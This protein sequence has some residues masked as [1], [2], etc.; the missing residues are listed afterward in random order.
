M[1][2][3]SWYLTPNKKKWYQNYCKNIHKNDKEMNKQILLEMLSYGTKTQDIELI[4][5]ASLHGR[6]LIKYFFDRDRIKDIVNSGNTNFAI[7]I[8]EALYNNYN[9]RSYNYDNYSLLGII[10]NQNDDISHEIIRCLIK[11]TKVGNSEPI[12]HDI[13]RYNVSHFTAIKCMQS[14][15]YDKYYDLFVFYNSI[16]TCEYNKLTAIDKKTTLDILL[17]LEDQN[18]DNSAFTNLPG[19]FTNL[20]GY[21][22]DLPGYFTNPSF[23]KILKFLISKNAKVSCTTINIKTINI[24]YECGYDFKISLENNAKSIVEIFLNKS[25]RI[26]PNTNIITCTTNNKEIITKLLDYD[27][28]KHLDTV[29]INYIPFD[30]KKNWY[31]NYVD[32]NKQ[33]TDIDFLNNMINHGLDIRCI[34][35]I[36]LAFLYNDTGAIP[37]VITNICDE[38]K[39]LL[40]IKQR[41]F[42]LDCLDLLN[43]IKYNFYNYDTTYGCNFL[44]LVLGEKDIDLT[45]VKKAYAFYNNDNNDMCINIKKDWNITTF[46]MLRYSYICFDNYFIDRSENNYELLEFYNDNINLEYNKLNIVNNHIYSALDMLLSLAH[47]EYFGNPNFMKSVTLLINSNAKITTALLE[48]PVVTSKLMKSIKLLIDCKYDFNTSLEPNKTTLDIFFEKV[49][50]FNKRYSDIFELLILNNATFDNKWLRMQLPLPQ[51]LF[52][53]YEITKEE[54][55]ICANITNVIKCN[56]GHFTCY[57]CIESEKDKKCLGCFQSF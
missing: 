11:V 22:T 36:R 12:I 21:F 5:L 14:N 27:V 45:I 7:R 29:I 13:K 9:F 8:L 39:K 28:G 1:N 4:N 34:E 23:I 44:G 56:Y 54:C 15:N 43:N 49:N 42:I 38:F 57:D 25:I 48:T 47:H 30:L 35:L 32:Y 46:L 52:K 18:N 31:I 3:I 50:I 41:E 20:P 24:L 10:L 17:S 33:I 19:Y 16:M 26:I 53:F 51:R 55:I 40:Y 6:F 37:N 2:R